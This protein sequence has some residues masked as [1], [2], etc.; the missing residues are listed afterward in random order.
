MQRRQFGLLL[1]S[2]VVFLGCAKSEAPAKPAE[3]KRLTVDEVAAKLAAKDGKTFIYDANTKDS[4]LNGHVP[5]ATWIDDENI[6]AAQLPS[7]RSALLVFYCHDE[8]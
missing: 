2:A 8:A 4:W 1:V 7:E 6:T 3:L 5:S